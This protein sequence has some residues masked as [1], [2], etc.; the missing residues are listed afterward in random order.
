MESVKRSGPKPLASEDARLLA[1]M[2]WV[3]IRR[4]SF[5]YRIGN[6]LFSKTMRLFPR[7]AFSVYFLIFHANTK[8]NLI[9]K[10]SMHTRKHH[11]SKEKTPVLADFRKRFKRCWRPLRWDGCSA[12]TKATTLMTH[13]LRKCHF[14]FF[15]VLKWIIGKVSFLD[16]LVCAFF[17]TLQHTIRRVSYTWQ[18]YTRLYIWYNAPSFILAPW[19]LFN[20]NHLLFST[21]ISLIRRIASNAMCRSKQAR[22]ADCLP[23]NLWY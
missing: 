12:K 13:C 14:C 11:L 10:I 17:C 2:F 3:Q 21:S 1:Y 7:I 15:L 9:Q 20:L 4:F 5:S 22:Y 18:Q 19:H 23:C 8:I 16:K 6:D